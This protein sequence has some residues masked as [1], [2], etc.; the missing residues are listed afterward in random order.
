M[1]C[2]YVYLFAVGF[3]YDAVTIIPPQQAETWVIHSL[4]TVD[5]AEENLEV[6]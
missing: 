2:M 1:V 6:V 3:M 5:N 4:D